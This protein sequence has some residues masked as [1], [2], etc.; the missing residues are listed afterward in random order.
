MNN[1][2]Q[3]RIFIPNKKPFDNVNWYESVLGNII[4]PI[5]REYKLLNFW[6]SKYDCSIDIDS[7]DCNMNKILEKIQPDEYNNLKSIRFRYDSSS[8]IFPDHLKSDLQERIKQFNCVIS[9]FRDYDYIKNLSNE[10]HLSDE[11]ILDV[12]DI[13]IRAE[14]ISN[15][16]CAISKLTLHNL[17]GPNIDGYY[18]FEYNHDTPFNSSFA[19]PFHLFC[20]IT[21]IPTEVYL[22]SK[23]YGVAIIR[24]S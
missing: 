24:W 6:F 16:Y 2:I 14:L 3:T 19:I 17:V 5:K 10:Q 23:A 11:N 13:N 9:D 4:N 22:P 12:E 20:N 1:W 15:L 21:Q 7:D 8:T 18:D